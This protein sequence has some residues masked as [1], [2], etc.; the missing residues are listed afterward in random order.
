MFETSK[1]HLITELFSPSFFFQATPDHAV[2]EAFACPRVK[3]FK[4]SL[5]L[6]KS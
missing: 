6:S 4:N 3:R 2:N 5:I 1:D